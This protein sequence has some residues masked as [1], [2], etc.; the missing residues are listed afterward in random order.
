MYIGAR[1]QSQLLEALAEAAGWGI[2]EQPGIHIEFKS[3]LSYIARPYLK[4]KQTTSYHKKKKNSAMNL[5]EAN[6]QDTDG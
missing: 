1:L 3:I 2:W 6:T 4:N 5:D